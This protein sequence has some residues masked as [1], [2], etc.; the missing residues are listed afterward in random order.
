[1]IT[2]FF[3]PR[4]TQCDESNG[5]IS[6]ERAVSVCRCVGQDKCFITSKSFSFFYWYLSFHSSSSSSSSSSSPPP[7][8]PPPSSSSSSP[9]PPPPSSPPPPPSSPPPSSSLLLLL[10]LLIDRRYTESPVCK[11]NVA[12]FSRFSLLP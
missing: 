12:V 9:P 8:P 10:P 1:M 11:M 4:D 2:T 7:P 3:R 5:A 6:G